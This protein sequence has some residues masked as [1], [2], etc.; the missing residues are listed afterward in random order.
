MAVPNFQVLML[1]LLEHLG[2]GTIHTISDS[3]DGVAQRLGISADD[4][5][6]MLPSGRGARFANR[7]YWARLHLKAA[8]LVELLGRGQFR[9][10][11]EGIDL[12][13]SEPEALTIKFLARYPS[14]VEFRTRRHDP[15]EPA[16]VIEDGEQTPEEALEQNYAALR[17]ALAAE[18]LD[19]V[20]AATPR[21]FEQLV[22]DVLV[23]MGY[24]GTRQDAGEAIGQT[25]DGGVDGVIREDKLG[26]DVI[27]LQAKRWEAV[28]GRPTVQAFAGSLEGFRA[29]K[30]VL[31]T[32]SHFS[33]EAR[34]YVS[35]IEKRIVLIDGH[36]LADLMIDHDVGV[37]GLATYRIKRVDEDFFDEELPSAAPGSDDAPEVAA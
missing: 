24:G 23:A 37:S 20:R 5:A 1:P 8:G 29:R 4:R 15:R 9:I 31:I 13:K 22:I 33:P 14:Y 34:E 3:A 26:L 32:T 28:V 17:G 36:T 25:G 18:L 12:L 16:V 19:R 30:G 11:Q 2:D 27:Y 6:E 10:T 35:K 21:F 7:V